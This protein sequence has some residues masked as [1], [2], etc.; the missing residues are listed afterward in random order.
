MRIYKAF[1]GDQAT[2]RIKTSLDG[3]LVA[4]LSGRHALTLWDSFTFER[5]ATFEVTAAFLDFAFS[6][7][8]AKIVLVTKEEQPDGTFTTD[9]RLQIYNIASKALE[10]EYSVDQVCSVTFLSEHCD[11]DA[12]QLMGCLIDFHLRLKQLNDKTGISGR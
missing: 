11:Q 6:F 8:R 7:D 10:N 9:S 1:E 3:A 2:T 4:S 5:I 12:K